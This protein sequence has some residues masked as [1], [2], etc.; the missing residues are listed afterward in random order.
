MWE[1]AIELDPGYTGAYVWLGFSYAVAYMSLW[2][3]DAG[4][5]DRAAERADK[6]IALDDSF[7]LGYSLRAW[8]ALLRGR[9]DKALADGKRGVSLSPN[10]AFAWSTLASIDHELGKPEEQLEC[11][12]RAMRL[13]PRHPQIYLSHEGWAY[14]E[15]GRF[16]EAVE[17]LKRAGDGGY[18][19]NHVYLASAYSE[20]GREQEAR[21]EAAE[22][23]RLS[24]GFSLEKV[25]Q[26]FPYLHDL[27]QPHFL[28]DLRKA[29]L[30]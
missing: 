6:A 21:A 14:Y 3:T 20:L 29:G 8:V 12:Q 4:V 27:R 11:A 30:K 2:D 7:G 10:N 22:V 15:M 1:K 5:L 18:F 13:D 26:R 17:A 25:K 19:W 23:L 16:A 28:A 24:P 9:P